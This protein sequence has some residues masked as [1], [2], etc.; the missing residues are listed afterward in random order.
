MKHVWV[1]FED[2]SPDE[3]YDLSEG[4]YRGFKEWSRIGVAYERT[5][6]FGH[7]RKQRRHGA[8]EVLIVGSPVELAQR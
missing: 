2:G 7:R 5:K 8:D 4:V 3:H 6:L 1:K